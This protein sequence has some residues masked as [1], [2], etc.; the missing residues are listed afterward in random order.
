MTFTKAIGTITLI[1]KEAIKE[2]KYKKI[3]TWKSDIGTSM[4]LIDGSEISNLENFAAFGMPF[5]K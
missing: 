2:I 3:T 5:F 4:V 1:R